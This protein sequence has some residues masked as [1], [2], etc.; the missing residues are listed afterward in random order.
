MAVQAVARVGFEAE[1]VGLWWDGHFPEQEKALKKFSTYGY[2]GPNSI[3]LTGAVGT[4]KTAFLCVMLKHK[5]KTWA[6]MVASEMT[7]LLPITFPLGT[8]YVTHMDIRQSCLNQSRREHEQVDAPD[9]NDLVNCSH[10]IIDDLFTAPETPYVVASVEEL[11]R[12]RAANKKRTWVTTNISEKDMKNK[13]K[14]PDWERVISRL[15]S[16]KW[17]AL[18]ELKGE[19]RRK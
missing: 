11:F 7:D 14:F 18:V 3:L 9:Y 12:Q 4:G 8:T 1:F 19:D 2:E 15:S 5:F 13:R 6:A 10:L 16:R 17:C